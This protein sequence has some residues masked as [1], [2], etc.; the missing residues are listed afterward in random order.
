M[1]VTM[2]RSAGTRVAR[3]P[4]QRFDWPATLALHLLP[5]AATF[6]AAFALRAPVRALD[7]PPQF[8]LTLAFAFVLTPIQ[9]G[10]L[11]HA[12]HRVTGRWSLVAL[13][14]VLSFQRRLP[15]RLYLMLLPSL[16]AIALGVAILLDPDLVPAGAGTGVLAATLVVD[17]L[18]RPVAQEVYFRAYL[19]PR[20]PVGGGLAVLTSAAL[21]TVQFAWH[22]Q[23]AVFMFVVQLMLAAV[24]VRL[25]SVRVTIA[26]HC[27]IAAAAPLAAL[28]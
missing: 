22:P 8:A 26:A 24:T 20:L 2:T 3:H 5:V 27:L 18:L 4:A 13:P 19:L 17:G 11:L 15:P 14:S 16:A 6:A 12:A 21:S 23:P 25:G 9:L 1:T 7:L 28:L 10:L